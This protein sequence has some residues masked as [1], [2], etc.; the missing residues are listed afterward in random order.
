M[1]GMA[2]GSVIDMGQ[3]REAVDVVL[4]QQSLEEALWRQGWCGFPVP[5]VLMP[6]A[7]G[8]DHVVDAPVVGI[9][10]EWRVPGHLQ[11]MLERGCTE[12]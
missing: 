10:G 8:L 1:Q 11:Q 12:K 5:P 9:V 7:E 3:E 4:P 6:M 2:E